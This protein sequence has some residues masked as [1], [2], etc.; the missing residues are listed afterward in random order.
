MTVEV[1]VRV[2]GDV[3]RNRLAV[4]PSPAERLVVPIAGEDLPAVTGDLVV[5]VDGEPS[6]ALIG[7]HEGASTRVGTIAGDLVMELVAVEPILVFHRPTPI[8]R[9]AGDFVV[10][11]DLARAAVLVDAWDGST[12]T[13]VL[14][15][16]P[17]V[18]SPDAAAQVLAG[19][20]ADRVTA[21]VA[22]TGAGLVIFD[23]PAA[24]G[25][26]AEV[27]GRSTEVVAADVAFAAVWVTAGDHVVDLRYRP[28]HLWWS[29]L[30]AML[31]LGAVVAHVRR[32]D[33]AEG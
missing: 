27:D 16:G 8:A 28:P 1:E 24:P 6:V 2:D 3:R 23:V 13:A 21:H 14:L 12:P 33:G 20:S 10:Q 4:A 9:F 31:G 22:A 5:R 19:R 26:R 11:P 25:W 18:V 17:P 32:P 15:D 29:S 7:L 30:V